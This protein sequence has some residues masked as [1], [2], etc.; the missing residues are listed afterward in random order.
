MSDETEYLERNP[1]A[2]AAV[3]R[4]ERRLILDGLGWWFAALA[5]A[6]ALIAG[7]MLMT[8]RH[9]AQALQAAAQD[10]ATV[11]ARMDNAATDA[12]LSALKASRAAQQA[13]AETARVT[14]MAAQTAAATVADALPAPSP[15]ALMPAPEPDPATLTVLADQSAA[16]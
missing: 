9:D 6:V 1:D 16:P 13:V 2:S 11:Q 12:Q 8:D 10:Q 7:L 14:D 4:E 15:E 3:Q 5:A